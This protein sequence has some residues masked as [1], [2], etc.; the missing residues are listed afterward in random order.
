MNCNIII[1]L[2]CIH[3][4]YLCMYLFI[5]FHKFNFDGLAHNYFGTLDELI[6]TLWNK[7]LI[8]FIKIQM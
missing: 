2:S 1:F 6:R 5:Y 3:D 4:I 8:Y 7:C